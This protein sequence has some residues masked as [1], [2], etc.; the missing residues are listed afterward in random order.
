MPASIFDHH[1]ETAYSWHGGMWSPLYAFASS[2]IAEDD[3]IVTDNYA[4]EAGSL[5]EAKALIAEDE[6]R[7]WVSRNDGETPFAPPYHTG[8]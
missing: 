8:E 6:E 2:G 3:S 7:F 5:A 1:R 4:V